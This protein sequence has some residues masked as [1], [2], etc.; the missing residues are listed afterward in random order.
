M[1]RQH[2]VVGGDDR[3]VRRRSPSRSAAL[4]VRAAGGE[5]M[6][7]IGAAELLA[8]RPLRNRV[9]DAVEIAP[10]RVAA[11]LGDA[12][13]DFAD[14]GV[15]GSGHGQPFERASRL[16][17]RGRNLW[18]F[19]G[20]QKA[21]FKCASGRSPTARRPG[22][23]ASTRRPTRVAT[24]M[25]FR[26]EPFARP[27]GWGKGMR[28]RMRLFPF[29]RTSGPPSS[30]KSVPNISKFPALFSK[31]FQRFLWPFH[32]KSMACKA[33][34]E[35]FVLLQVFAPIPAQKS[36][37]SPADNARMA[38]RVDGNIA[39]ISLFQ[40]ALLGSRNCSVFIALGRRSHRRDAV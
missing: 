25:R 23:R 16:N 9:V 13:G 33:K 11:A 7:E 27:R 35:N 24:M 4:V 19:G 2:V 34:K 8:R 32:V 30:S 17:A 12:F 37:L 5:A 28:S 20:E 26:F 15:K 1:R 14:A 38:E 3:Q 10:A 39:R 21:G 6:G 29:V 22:L 40:K 31:Y 36:P 18:R